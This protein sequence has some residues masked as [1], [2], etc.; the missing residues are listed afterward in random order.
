MIRTV[1][2]DVL[3]NFDDIPYYFDNES[4]CWGAGAYA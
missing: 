4:D 3:S 1:S 2:N